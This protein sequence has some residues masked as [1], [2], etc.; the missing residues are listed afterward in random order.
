M[1]GS[2]LVGYLNDMPPSMDPAPVI[3]FVVA[4]FNASGALDRPIEILRRD[5][6]SPPLGRLGDVDRAMRE[7]A[8]AGVVGIV[9]LSISESAV[10]LQRLINRLEVPV[11]STGALSGVPSPWCFQI[12][13][14]SPGDEATV[15]A[16]W[17][18]DQGCR[19]IGMFADAAFDQEYAHFFRI[20]ARRFGLALAGE[21][22]IPLVVPGGRS[23]AAAGA[24]ERFRRAGVDGIAALNWGLN[25]E[26]VMRAVHEAGWEVP[27]IAAAAYVVADFPE[28]T[29][30]FEGWVGTTSYDEENPTL[31]QLL[32]R[33]A[34]AR[35]E[36]YPFPEVAGVFATMMMATLEGLRIAP[37]CSPDGL[38][39]G[40][41]R[42][43]LLPSASGS[44]R[45]TV[46]FGPHDH[47]GLKGADGIVL[48]RI[49]SG[50]NIKEPPWQP[51]IS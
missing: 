37:N 39:V 34:A 50:Q 9:G 41:E 21:A 19:T 29:P 12:N 45:A 13:W 27:R 1:A 42:I 26:A 4:E 3:E 11:V 8:E 10:P 40:L 14:A 6:P 51:W 23:Q 38:R 32:T 24:V 44:A 33:Y 43:R 7:L 47:R 48:R 20:A 5:V 15:A 46:S 16:K 28:I 30:L 36:E 18:A 2:I 35:G 49:R 22:M 17:L 31:A 25:I